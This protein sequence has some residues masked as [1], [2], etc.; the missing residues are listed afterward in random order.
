[1]LLFLWDIAAPIF[2]F[3]PWCLNSKFL[4][5]IRKYVH[6][7]KNISLNLH[8]SL[9]SWSNS[10]LLLTNKLISILIY[11]PGNA[12][13]SCLHSL[14][15]FL[16]ISWISC[17]SLNH[18]C[19]YNEQIHPTVLSFWKCRLH[20]SIKSPPVISLLWLSPD[21]SLTLRQLL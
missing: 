13:F 20:L 4:P 14:S 9:T 18:W 10:G 19:C 12:S 17:L 2:P 1:M 7:S 6:I 16:L 5:C 3:L 15:D 21:S 11:S 8:C